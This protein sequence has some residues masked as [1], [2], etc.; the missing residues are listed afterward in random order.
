M[1]GELGA[2]SWE[3]IRV[4]TYFTQRESSVLFRLFRAELN[5]RERASLHRLAGGN[6][7][8]S[9]RVYLYLLP[10]SQQISN[11]RSFK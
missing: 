5:E 11:G 10:L 1:A 2:G 6:D 7:G 9:E 4:I 3:L 8:D